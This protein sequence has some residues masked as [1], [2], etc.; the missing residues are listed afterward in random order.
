MTSSTLTM[1]GHTQSTEDSF[2]STFRPVITRSLSPEVNTLSPQGKY[3]NAHLNKGSLRWESRPVEF[4][5]RNLI[6]GIFTVKLSNRFAER[7]IMQPTA[8]CRKIAAQL[9]GTLLRSYEMYPERFEA[10]VEEGVGLIYKNYEA[11]KI[12]V[13]E[14]YNT[15]EIAAIIN[16]DKQILGAWDIVNENDQVLTDVI[17][18]FKE[19]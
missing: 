3:I 19:F 7:G 11:N 15:T 12:L 18:T 9:A 2:L 17:R 13:I 16:S 1:S 6:I 10:S 4:S 8:N 5:E 14:V